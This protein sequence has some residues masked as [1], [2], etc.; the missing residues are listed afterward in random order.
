MMILSSSGRF[1]DASITFENELT[2]VLRYALRSS[3]CSSTSSST[4]TFAFMYGSRW[5]T[6]RILIRVTPC[7]RRRISPLGNR[8]IFWMWTAVPTL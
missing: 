7:P 2:T 1:S 4:S 5:V 8:I 6:E 3:D